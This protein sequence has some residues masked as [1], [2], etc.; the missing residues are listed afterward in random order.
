V[1]KKY[2]FSALLTTVPK[3]QFYECLELLND[4]YPI[5]KNYI[6]NFPIEVSTTNKYHDIER[7]SIK[8]NSNNKEL[9][10][11][12][13]S[14]PPNIIINTQK[15]H[16]VL[17]DIKKK[18]VNLGNRIVKFLGL[19]ELDVSTSN[20]HF[21]DKLD[22]L[23]RLN[24]MSMYLSKYNWSDYKIQLI[25]SGEMNARR[26]VFYIPFKFRIEQIE[27]VI[28][29]VEKRSTSEA[30]GVPIED[31][32]P[33]KE[34]NKPK[35]LEEEEKSFNEKRDLIEKLN[36]DNEPTKEMMKREFKKVMK[37]YKVQNPKV[38]ANYM[39]EE[40]DGNHFTYENNEKKSMDIE[41]EFLNPNIFKK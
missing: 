23:H 3:V 35:I 11:F 37:E 17:M 39:Y 5:Y 27:K 14:I 20:H 18:S 21:V 36:A 34:K 7:T 10:K 26:G 6:M 28:K 19:N 40:D 4:N 22:F 41:Y 25:D 1:K 38:Y 29:D 15:Y 9:L 33:I 16:T 8:W 32:K 30:L 31:E 12:F 2:N 24:H 13:K